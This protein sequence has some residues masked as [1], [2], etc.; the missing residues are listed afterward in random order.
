MFP[1]PDRW[2][3]NTSLFSSATLLYFS[4]GANLKTQPLPSPR[5][6]GLRR[7]LAF[8]WP[9]H[10]QAE[11]LCV[12]APSSLVFAA[13]GLPLQPTVYVH[14]ADQPP[15]TDINSGKRNTTTMCECSLTVNISL[16]V[17][18]PPCQRS[19]FFFSSFFSSKVPSWTDSQRCGFNVSQNKWSLQKKKKEMKKKRKVKRVPYLPLS[20]AT[21]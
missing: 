11:R 6:G 10:R 13:G 20:V 21:L 7:P 19:F 1:P 5:V 9:L 12:Y 4:T 3:L 15:S 8:A 2:T 14:S 16:A 18:C 17:S